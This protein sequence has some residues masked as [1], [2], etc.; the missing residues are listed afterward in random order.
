MVT[1]GWAWRWML[2]RR[3]VIMKR[4]LGW[5]NSKRK[6]KKMVPVGDGNVA[7]VWSIIHYEECRR[8]AWSFVICISKCLYKGNLT[9]LSLSNLAHFSIKLVEGRIK[10]SSSHLQLELK[11][12]LSRRTQNLM[13]NLLH[14]RSHVQVF[15]IY[16]MH[17]MFIYT[18]M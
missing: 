15:I 12:F 5:R 9:C 14:H 2:D 16:A 6:K 4:S 10:T 11:G 8:K 3:K 1:E 18:K 7:P 17:G 13:W